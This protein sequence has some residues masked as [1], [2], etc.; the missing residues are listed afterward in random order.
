MAAPVREVVRRVEATRTVDADFALSE[1]SADGQRALCDA[2]FMQVVPGGCEGPPFIVTPPI[3]GR[4]RVVVRADVCRDQVL[5]GFAVNVAVQQSWRPRP[6]EDEVAARLV[7]LA[8]VFHSE[9][10][11]LP[12]W[13]GRAW[14]RERMER[15]RDVDGLWGADSLH[16]FLL[17]LD[18]ILPR[19]RPTAPDLNQSIPAEELAAI[20]REARD[21]AGDY[22][23]ALA[24]YA[25][26][27][28]AAA[29]AHQWDV[30]VR[31]LCGLARTCGMVGR[32]GEAR[33]WLRRALRQTSRHEMHGLRGEVY[34]ERFSVEVD[35]GC[36]AAALTFAQEA[37]R[38]YGTRHPML[39]RL[40]QDITSHLLNTRLY[41]RAL[42]LARV[43]ELRVSGGEWRPAV[44]S[45]LAIAGAGAG[46][47][48]ALAR[49]DY[50]L[51]EYLDTAGSA[52]Y[53]A[54]A[55]LALA[56]AHVLVGSWASAEASARTAIEVAGRHGESA[57]L[58]RAA[59]VLGCAE[60][61]RGL[62]SVRTTR[63]PAADR[64]WQELVAALEQAIRH[65]PQP[66]ASRTA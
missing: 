26:A 66:S 25:S 2:T 62:P 46:D 17:R 33:A 57:T 38:A 9:G 8:G 56:E 11:Q 41:L 12:G 27:S 30:A 7:G 49:A 45:N 28:D 14:Q 55:H 32:A 24:V 35:E 44:L 21:N 15:L 59:V 5:R 4:A 39:F 10:M 40:A 53:A 22:D 54:R 20:A 13:A 1:Q 51:R 36:D 23:M 47:L 6:C 65:Q 42:P 16:S 19:L 34:H 50:Q 3:R 52:V 31:A 61:R 64:L 48:K 43:L 60:H 29:R 37:F 18:P 58:N 63:K